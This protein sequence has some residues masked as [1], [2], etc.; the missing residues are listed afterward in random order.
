MPS[1]PRE[2]VER[3][4]RD[5]LRSLADL[6]HPLTLRVADAEGQVA[7]LILVWNA[8]QVMPTVGAERRRRAGCGR[9]D[10]KKDIVEVVSAAGRALTRKE[11]V[12]ALREAG[13]EHG[14]GTVAKALADLTG[15]GELVNPKDKKGYRIPD[16]VRRS[17][18]PSLF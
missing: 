18:T 14:V 2:A 7:C 4:A 8:A 6:P 15:S 9:A 3:A 16:W 17:K 11:V 5:L 12:K 10:C 13:K 1:D